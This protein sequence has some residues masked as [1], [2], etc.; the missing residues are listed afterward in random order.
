MKLGKRIRELWQMRP[1]VG[2]SAALATVV[3][4]WSVAQVSILPPRI[5]SRSLE[6]ATAAT[7]VVVDTPRSTILDL[8]ENTYSLEALRQRAIVLG[9]VIAN[10]EVREAIA[11]HANVPADELQ[12]APP[13]TPNQPRAVV[14]STDRKHATD[15]LASTDQY[16]LS[17]QANPTVPMLDI[18]AQ[19]PNAASAALLAN[20]A[21]GQLRAYLTELAASERTPELH[22]VRLL[23][24]G[25]AEGAVINPGIDVQVVLLVF[26]ITFATACATLFF[27]SRVRDGWRAEALRERSAER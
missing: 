7:H 23:Q 16:R 22:Q 18:Y 19:A 4:I 9:N 6:M 21:V 10:G 12:I 2:A 13:L 17:I 27:A 24:L 1:L 15:L 8:R 11:R 26:V 14:A 20:S 3:A 25:R 5:E